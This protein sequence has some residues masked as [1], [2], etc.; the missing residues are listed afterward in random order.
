MHSWLAA[1]TI[2]AVCAS[3][4][5]AINPG[6]FDRFGGWKA[7][8]FKPGG[9][10]RTHHDGQRWWLV[11]PEGHAFISIGVN[12]VSPI[13]D[14]IRRSSRHPYDESVRAKYGTVKAWAQSTRDRLHQWGFN[15]LAGWSTR[16]VPEMP[17]TD[18]FGFSGGG[19][20]LKGGMPDYFGTGF[21]EH[22]ARAA[23]GCRASH[24]DPWLIGYF[25]DNELAWDTDWRLVPNLFDRYA[26]LPAATPGK[27]AWCRLLRD[28]HQTRDAFNRVW[29]PSIKGWD[30]LTTLTRLTPR[31]DQ[32]E[33]AKADCEAFA[34]LVARQYFR[35]CAEA[36]RKEDPHH[37]ILGSRFVSW[38][39]PRAVVQACGEFC[40]VVSINFYEMGVV[41]LAAYRTRPASPDWRPDQ[42]DFEPFYK[43]SGKPLMITEFSFRSMDSGMPNTYPP[44]LAVQPNVPTQ[45]VRAERYAQYVQMWMSRPFFVGYHWFEWADEPKEGRFDGE[46]GNYGLVNIHDEPYHVFVEAVR[47]V[48]G[49]VWSLHRK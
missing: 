25:L 26:T 11:T 30:D 34:L 43:A 24:D 39:V 28:R 14:A 36:I 18:V 21:I 46:N 45:K 12:H 40:D 32:A 1:L 20:W 15:T 7:I 3:D 44:P 31:E 9:F 16:D 6:E 29:T 2:A 41:G 8:R 48:N 17:R 10:F 38:T 4:D 49:R 35:T 19:N 5:R 33:A 13:G 37:L 27:Q 42:L 22:A 23:Q 47:R